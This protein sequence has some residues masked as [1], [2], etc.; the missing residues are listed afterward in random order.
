MKNELV[1]LSLPSENPEKI[2]SDCQ[3]S[4]ELFQN[5]RQTMGELHDIMRQTG[6]S[7]DFIRHEIDLANRRL[8]PLDKALQSMDPYTT[9]PGKSLQGLPSNIF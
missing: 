7:W 8:S 1:K 3:M 6:I 5:A 2:S 9:G 4:V